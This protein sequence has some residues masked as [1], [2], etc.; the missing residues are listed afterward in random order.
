MTPAEANC[1]SCRFWLGTPDPD[2]RLH[3]VGQCRRYPPGRQGYPRAT[4]GEWCGE[5]E[6]QYPPEA[7]PVT[8]APPAPP[9]PLS[10]PSPG[11]YTIMRQHLARWHGHQ[12]G[13]NG[14]GEI[15][16]TTMALMRQ[17]HDGEHSCRPGYHRAE[18]FRPHHHPS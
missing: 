4:E 6:A 18:G 3:A 12:A 14:A 10:S 13:R 16:D 2:P 8:A 7:H 11:T 1:G 15:A 5:H 17:Q 9:Q